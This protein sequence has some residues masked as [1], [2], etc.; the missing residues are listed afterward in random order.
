MRAFA[1][2]WTEEEVVQQPVGQIPWGTTS[3]S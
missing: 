2:A 3:C 1:G